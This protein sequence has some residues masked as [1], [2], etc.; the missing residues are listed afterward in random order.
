MTQIKRDVITVSLMIDGVASRELPPPTN[1]IW[2]YDASG[3]LTRHQTDGDGDG[4]PDYI[5]TW[6]FDANGDLT[7]YQKDEDGNGAPDQT[8]F[9]KDSMTM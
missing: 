5:E 2:Q 9:G 8:K 3:N 1:E 6:E 7:R 4:A